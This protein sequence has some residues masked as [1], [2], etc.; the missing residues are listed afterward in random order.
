VPAVPEALTWLSTVVAQLPDLP[1]K[2]YATDPK[3]YVILFGAGFAIGVLGHIVKVKAMVVAG[4]LMVFLATVAL[5]LVT[6][7]GY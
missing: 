3:P 7:L 4:V 6:R 5:P 1:D 2:R